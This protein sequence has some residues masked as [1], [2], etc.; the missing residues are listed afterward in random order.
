MSKLWYSHITICYITEGIKQI[1]IYLS[2][3]IYD[4]NIVTYSKLVIHAENYMMYIT[5]STQEHIS[6]WFVI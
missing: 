1:Y 5:L 2:T 4:I 6:V 3:W